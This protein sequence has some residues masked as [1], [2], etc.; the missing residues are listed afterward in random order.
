MI[1]FTSRLRDAVLLAFLLFALGCSHAGSGHDYRRCKSGKLREIALGM[2]KNTI[3]EYCSGKH[4]IGF[5]VLV[6]I[7][8]DDGHC[9]IKKTIRR[10]LNLVYEVA[11]IA[12]LY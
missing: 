12:G 9:F 11:K 10:S 4:K 7:R 2:Q 3:R 1:L 5:T 6:D 8:K